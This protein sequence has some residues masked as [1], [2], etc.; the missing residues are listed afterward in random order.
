MVFDRVLTDAE[1]SGDVLLGWPAI[2]R[3]MISC[4][5]SV[6]VATRAVAV[7]AAPIRS[8]SALTAPLT[9]VN[10][11][12]P[13][14]N[15]IAQIIARTV[16]LAILSEQKIAKVIQLLKG[17]RQDRPQVQDRVDQQADQMAQQPAEHASPQAGGGRTILALDPAKVVEDREMRD[18]PGS[19]R[20][21]LFYSSSRGLPTCPRRIRIKFPQ[22]TRTNESAPQTG[23]S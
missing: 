22:Y 3:F 20:R 4:H 9:G 11:P 18:N 1:I 10:R 13:N 7:P 5:R 23:R 8:A 19:T 2:T 15:I 21:S 17:L 12:K 14:A 6:S 16:E